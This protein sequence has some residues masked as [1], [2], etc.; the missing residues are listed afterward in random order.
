MKQHRPA[1]APTGPF[2]R[3]PEQWAAL[4]HPPPF[5]EPAD[6]DDD[7]DDPDYPDYPHDPDG[8]ATAPAPAPAP[9]REQAAQILIEHSALTPAEL[10][11][12]HKAARGQRSVLKMRRNQAAALLARWQGPIPGLHLTP[13]HRHPA[14]GPDATAE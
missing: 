9:T 6:P 3:T 5:G 14:T 7:P 12:L 13:L 10:N 2:R 1:A 11:E 4:G 8:D